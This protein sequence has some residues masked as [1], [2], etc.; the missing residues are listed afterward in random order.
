MLEKFPDCILAKIRK[1]LTLITKGQWEDVP[2]IFN[3][4]EGLYNLLSDRK[5]FN[6]LEVIGFHTIMAIYFIGE[7]DV[8][9]AIVHS[10]SVEDIEAEFQDEGA[11]NTFEEGIYLEVLML[12]AREVMEWVEVKGGQSTITEACLA[13]DL[14]L[15]CPF[16]F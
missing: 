7:M 4:N 14:F 10:T 11:S 15:I 9:K 16:F 13:L 3:G 2:T 8:L 12:K 1:G 5:A 6:L